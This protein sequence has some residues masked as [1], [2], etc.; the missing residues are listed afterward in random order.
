M[1]K[2]LNAFRTYV[3]HSKIIAYVPTS[4]VK[5][6]LVQPD[7]DGKRGQWIAKIQELDLEIKPIKLI[8]GQGLAKILAE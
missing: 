7:N 1:V 3:L 4:S 5:D 8:K 6:I 2:A